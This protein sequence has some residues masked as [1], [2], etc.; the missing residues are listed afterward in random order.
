MSHSQKFSALL[1]PD[2]LKITKL[3]KSCQAKISQMRNK[4]STKA[5][6]VIISS[7]KFFAFM[8]LSSKTN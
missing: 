7:I 6:N 5:I 4:F 3:K 2:S 1:S 8:T